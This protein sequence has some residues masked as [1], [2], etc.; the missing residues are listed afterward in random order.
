LAIAVF[1]VA[2]VFAVG[3]GSVRTGAKRL[4][5]AVDAAKAAP[6][7]PV[8]DGA[9]LVRSPATA[10]RARV[11]LFPGLRTGQEFWAAQPYAGF[12]DDLVHAGHQVVLAA[13]PYAHA[14]FYADGGRVYCDSFRRWLAAT[15]QQLEAAHGKAPRQIA[16]GVSY[17]G[18]HAMIAAAVPGIHGFAAVSPVTDVGALNEF[19]WASNEHCGPGAVL[20]QLAAIP[21][22]IV[23]QDRDRR[24]RGE[25]T[26]AL[27]EQLRER[28]AP[29]TVHRIDSP[30][31]RI[32]EEIL[33]EVT[34]WIEKE[35]GR[36][37]GGPG[38]AIQ[39]GGRARG[40][41]AP[42]AGPML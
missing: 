18:M 20:P 5:S 39:G 3:G 11:F 1:A 16:A 15:M 23:Y 6:G 26:T 9:V 29:L 38:P 35:A 32:T 25:F 27:V 30:E 41:S 37:E 13:L 2:A 24:V 17:G 34:K 42:A 28:G 7:A 14:S 33:A 12:V 31:H 10:P 8:F 36:T 4:Q 21:G 22:V 19:W 40:N